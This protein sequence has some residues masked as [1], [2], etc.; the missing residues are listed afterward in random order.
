[1][2]GGAGPGSDL[3]TMCALGGLDPVNPLGASVPLIVPAPQATVLGNL[4][5]ALLVVAPVALFADDFE[6]ADTS[7]WSVVSP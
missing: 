3:T 2:T 7:A 4:T 5:E 6:S 1:M